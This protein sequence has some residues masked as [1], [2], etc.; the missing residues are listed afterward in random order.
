[1]DAAT[2]AEL[3]ADPS[4]LEALTEDQLPEVLGE[5]ERLRAQVWAQLSRPSLPSGATVGM[6][7]GEPDTMLNAEA[8]AEILNVDARYVYD[9]ADDWPFTRRLSART[10]R[11]SERGL[12]RWLES[13]R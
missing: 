1:M 5:L 10:L 6:N 7:G 12:Y 3:A 11:F 2:L 9:H 13:C 8:V 4:R